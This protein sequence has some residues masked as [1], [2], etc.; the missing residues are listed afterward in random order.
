MCEI[1]LGAREG[2]NPHR[3]MGLI[4]ENFDGPKPDFGRISIGK[5]KTFFAIQQDSV[6][7]LLQVMKGAEWGG[8]KVF[9][10]KMP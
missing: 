7:S 3:L 8:K 5:K 6:G 9:V 1:N 10:S 2:L 4:N